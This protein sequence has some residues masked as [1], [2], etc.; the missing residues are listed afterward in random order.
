MS[1][2]FPILNTERLVLR[3]ITQED[4][5]DIFT[6]LSDPEVMKYYGLAP[7]ESE[8]EALE[9]I[10]WYG[11]IFESNV[12]IRWG[13]TLK[14]T[15]IIIGSCGFLNWEKR[16][17]RAEVGYELAKEHWNK[18]IMREALEAVIHY[19]FTTYEINRIQALVEQENIA[20]LRLLKKVGFNEEGILKEYERTSGKYD[21]LVMLSYLRRDY[22][23]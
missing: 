19:G 8:D 2:L 16:H 4:S 22:N 1:E 15:D 11:S 3:Q 10:E 12:G 21:D 6:Y 9:E 18:G 13:I 20:S 17:N 7:F 14:G 5:S 23:K